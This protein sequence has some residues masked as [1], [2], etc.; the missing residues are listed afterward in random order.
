[1][2]SQRLAAEN[3]ST[4]ALVTEQTS[5]TQKTL[6]FYDSYMINDRSLV[7]GKSIRNEGIGRPKV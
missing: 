4:D 3:L 5:L 1:M 2:K 6:A 7:S